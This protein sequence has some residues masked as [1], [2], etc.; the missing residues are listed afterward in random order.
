MARRPYPT[1][2]GLTVCE[3]DDGCLESGR[4]QGETI[5]RP[6]TDWGRQGFCHRSP[7][8]GFPKVWILAYLYPVQTLHCPLPGD[9]ICR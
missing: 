5:P 3:R 9:T 2:R 6:L 1:L 7:R 4:V 8:K